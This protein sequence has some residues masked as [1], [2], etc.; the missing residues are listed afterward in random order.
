MF[1]SADDDTRL[2]LSDTQRE[3]VCDA[4]E[5]LQDK[6]K[7]L[8]KSVTVK[9]ES[10]T[11]G[12]KMFNALADR[13]VSKEPFMYTPPLVFLMSRAHAAATQEQSENFSLSS[14]ATV[15]LRSRSGGQGVSK[16]RGSVRVVRD[17]LRI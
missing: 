1:L 5:Q 2:C 9:D 7:L 14:S 12:K 3:V 16:R 4:A 6:S 8:S 10:S 11:L 13:A 17:M 15:Q